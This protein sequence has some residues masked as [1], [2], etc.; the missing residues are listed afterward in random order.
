VEKSV[1]PNDKAAKMI[2]AISRAFG[3][4]LRGQVITLH[5]ANPERAGCALCG[6][7]RRLT[8]SLGALALSRRRA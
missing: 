1:T 2:A 5:E 6:H 7:T 4:V 8:A 3:D